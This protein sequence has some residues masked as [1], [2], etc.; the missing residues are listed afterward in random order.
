MTAAAG[1][2]HRVI[3][4]DL[5]RAA[6]LAA[7]RTTWIERCALVAQLA[8]VLGENAP[9]L[10][11]AIAN[12]SD[13]LGPD[14][15]AEVRAAIDAC[16][17][18]GRNGPFWPVATSLQPGVVVAHTPLG[19][20]LW[21]LTRLAL[22]VLVGG[23]VVAVTY[24]G[25][26]AKTV[27]LLARAV[28]S[29]GFLQGTVTVLSDEPRPLNE[30]RTRRA[31][32]NYGAHPHDSPLDRGQSMVAA[33]ADDLPA[34][35]RRAVRRAGAPA[36]PVLPTTVRLVTTPPVYRELCRE[37]ARAVAQAPAVSWRTTTAAV[38]RIQV[39]VPM[40]L[41]EV[42]SD[43]DSALDLAHGTAFGLG[44]LLWE[45]VGSG[46]G[47]DPRH[48]PWQISEVWSAVAPGAETIDRR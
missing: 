6:L 32:Y 29:A 18:Y 12:D 35:A 22:P 41:V 48:R 33:S 15:G 46:R 5:S 44:G 40:V 39:E 25:R 19:N 7:D 8:T 26:S 21:R 24:P 3:G 16:A 4:P 14:A 23:G 27:D 17:F 34:L 47:H 37:V 20:P 43:L 2:K 31:T 36:S 28:E 30:V 1:A 38:P 42:A 10:E 13:K 45:D 9:A 11:R